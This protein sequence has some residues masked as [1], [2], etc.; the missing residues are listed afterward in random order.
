MRSLIE[1]HVPWSRKLVDQETTFQGTKIH[2]LS[3][4]LE[5]RE[6]M[7]LKYARSSQGEHVFL[8]KSMTSAAWEELVHKALAEGGWLAQEFVDPSPYYYQ[9]G[10]HSGGPHDGVWGLFVCGGTYGGGFLRILP[11]PDIDQP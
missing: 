4:L 1:R 8:G 7:I 6:E 2:L 9:S 3:C 11:R 10:K 5:H